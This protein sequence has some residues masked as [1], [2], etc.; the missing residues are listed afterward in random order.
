MSPALQPF[1]RVARAFGLVLFS[2]PAAAGIA[3][4]KHNLSASGSGSLKAT[5]ETQLC[6]FCHIPHNAAPNAPLWNRR[7]SSGSYTPYTSSTARAAAGQP[8]GASSTCLSCHDGTIALGDL[9]SR[10]TAVA[11]AAGVTTLPA[12]RSNLGTDLSDDHPV[13]IAY[14]TALATTRGEL[15]DPATLTGKVRLDGA[16]QLQCTS[17]HEPHD[18]S[19]GKFLVMSNAGSA[20]CQTCHLTSYWS[21]SSHRTSTATWNGSG[22][23]P[24]PHTSARTVAANACENCHRPHSAPGKKWLLNY[25]KEEDNCNSCHGGTVAA[26]NIK[27]EFSK[28]SIHRIATN[29]GTHDVAE[30]GVIPTRHVECAD[31]HNP[32]A[33]KSGGSPL[34]GSLAGLRG[35]TIGGTEV[36]PIALEYQLCFRCHGDSPNKPAAKITRQIVQTNL[37]L[38][39]NTGNPSF[40]PVAG[41]GKGTSVPSLIAPWT[42]AS[43]MKCTD[44]HNNNNNGPANGGSG[45]R[46]PHGSN[47]A[48]LLERQYLTA[49]YTTESATAYALCYKCHSRSV[50]L[51]SLNAVS[52]TVHNKHVVGEKTPCSACHDPH[53]ISSTQGNTTNNSRLVNWDTAI[54]KPDSSGRLRW[55]RTTA[56]HGRC[57]MR[58]HGDNHSPETY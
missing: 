23:N 19:N 21:T 56:G 46:G 22:T 47:Y 9:L 6:I 5:S 24:W 44:C 7:S 41:R 42:T 26:K 28:T 18:D 49:D 11:M 12:G 25:Q 48:P 39:F 35:I 34:P 14:T 50:L 30:A 37:R 20:L 1:F 31:C 8:T 17:C 38:E 40:H 43:T 16:G 4:S 51:N 33:V 52:S 2:L 58:C 53:G 32:H 10:S 13:S 27:A 15:A 57:Y 55:E 3:T 29:T 36:E 45:P 54:V